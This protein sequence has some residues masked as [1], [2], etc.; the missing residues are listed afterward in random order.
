MRRAHRQ[1]LALGWVE[2]PI[3]GLGVG[4]DFKGEPGPS[5]I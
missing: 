3:V 4:P 1:L 5:A 2:A